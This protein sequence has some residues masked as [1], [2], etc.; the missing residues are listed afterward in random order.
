MTRTIDFLTKHGKK[1]LFVLDS[2][3]LPFSP[4]SCIDRPISLL[5]KECKFERAIHNNRQ[6]NS[7]YNKLVKE[8]AEKYSNVE[9][10]DLADAFCND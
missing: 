7:L 1:V 4:A 6:S 5:K 8:Y 9:Y 2:P 3:S 10:I